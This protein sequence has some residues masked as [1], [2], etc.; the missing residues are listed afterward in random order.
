MTRWL[1]SLVCG[2]A[3]SFGAAAAPLAPGEV[4]DPLKSWVPWV[5]SDEAQ[6]GCPHLFNSAETRH[7][8]WPAV[9]ELKADA[10]GASFA[11]QWRAYR[12]TWAVLPGD[13]RQWP[14]EVLVDGKPA[15]VLS[16]DGLPAVRLE[17]GVHRISGRFFWS[18]LPLSLAL[19]AGAGLLQL[20]L[21]GKA[22]ALP[23]RDEHN[24]LL[25]Q[26][27]TEDREKEQ[28]QLRVY[29]KIIDGVPLMVETRL[30]LEV[31]GKNRE[32][33]IGRVLLPDLIPSELQS[34]LPAVLAEDGGLKLQA[35][36][37]TWDVVLLA[38]H[39]GL[40]A[41]LTLP[42][43]SG[44]QAEEE[45]WVFQAAP[46]VRSATVEGPPAVDPQQTTLPEE[47]RSLPS[48]L[49]RPKASFGLKQVRRGDSD[50]APDKLTLK[51]RLWLGFDGASMTAR[52]S[53]AGDIS[54]GTRLTLIGKGQLGRVDVAG[55]DQLIT[56]GGD[57]MAGI[58]VKRGK[59][60]M[61]ADSLLP[62]AVRRFAAVGWKHDFDRL[63]MELALPAGWRLLHA[64]GA[65]HQTGAWLSNWNLLDVF[66]VLLI[67]L[68]AG[69][70]WG[71]AWGVV[72]LVF[73]ILSYQE[74]N[75]PRFAWLLLLLAT[76]LWQALPDGRV[77][78]WIERIKKLSWFLLL[79]IALE[80]AAFEVRSALYPVL[81]RQTVD[82]L[83]FGPRL[84]ARIDGFSAKDGQ[85]RRQAEAN[86]RVQELEQA[87]TERGALELAK[88]KA[89]E[90]RAGD[91]VGAAGA[92][93]PSAKPRERLDRFA[94][95]VSSVSDGS[96]LKYAKDPNAKV[97]TGP[98]LPDWHWHAISL[99]W[100]GPVRQDQQL[101]LWLLSPVMNKFL[102]V[103][104]LLLLGLLLARAGGRALGGLGG[105][106][107]GG[108]FGRQLLLV[109]LAL[110]ALLHTASVWAQMPEPETLSELKS[111][112]T[113]PAECLPE[114]AEIS[115]LS[116]QAA[117]GELRLGLEVDAA[118][119]TALPL[120]GGARQW[121]P[122][123]ALLDGKTA[124]VQR[125][126]RGGLWLLTPAGHH[127]LELNGDLPHGDTLQLPLPR[128]PR[129]VDV[130]AADWDVSG[131]SDDTGAADTLQL[132]RRRSAG[133]QGEAPVLPPFLQVERR[134][135]LDLL[136]R[137]ETTVRRNSP[138]GVPA[139]AEVPLLPG[140]AVTSAGVNVK[141]GKVMVNLGPQVATLSW[142][143]NLTQ[144]P[145]IVLAAGR[146]L[147]WM[148][149][150]IVAASTTWH[151]G[152]DG[153]P[154][155]AAAP[156]Q[157]IDPTYRPWPGETLTL[158]IDRP[159]AVA[160][161]SL[162]IDA[163]TLTL[164]PG[165]RA[166]NYLLAMVIRSSRGVDHTVMLPDGTS[167]QR[168]KING[169]VRPI[170]AFGRQVSL[171]LVPGKQ[172]I[173]LAWR[174]DRGIGWSYDT[175]PVD[176]G[177]P[178]V[179]MRLNIKW[180]GER[181]LLLASGPGIGSVILFW[182]KLLLML[183]LGL[184][185][186]RYAS[187]K[188]P[189]KTRDWLLLALG[190]TQ[191]AN[192]AAV[193]VVCWFF[194]FAKRADNAAAQPSRRNFNMRQLA[195]PVLTL[196]MLAVLFQVVRGGLLGQPD[197][198]VAGVG[199]SGN[200]NLHWYLDRV[201][202]QMPTAWV[203]SLPILVYRGLML[204][205]ALWLAWSLLAWLQWGWGIYGKDGYWRK[206]PPVDKIGKTDSVGKADDVVNVEPAEPVQDKQ[207]G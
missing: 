112:L 34:P 177:L 173:E 80:F 77:K 141:D 151:V 6:H 99:G 128:K 40:A 155:V 9:L 179:N 90:T 193:L 191:I 188:L 154:P 97:Q 87:V 159:P 206:R 76:A 175:L 144:R 44:L 147:G 2:F 64:G 46:L 78:R 129:R 118:I 49:M 13:E 201:P 137:V 169:V 143:S 158:K 60:T 106:G 122:R 52:D 70:L 41:A 14:Q 26:R 62:G 166:S 133:R 21:N 189:M 10:R 27:K 160:G 95:S 7:C 115:R 56:R 28:A 180:P 58:E 84:F 38:R 186:G 120:P 85:A 91:E 61:S 16:Q 139:L 164:D 53:I 86:A 156:D 207:N 113:R 8:A 161:Q 182:S 104:R 74:V 204:L 198:Q 163:V 18:A 73:L 54:R 202:A 174:V 116:V 42:P 142:S 59:L 5:L 138:L 11:Q 196:L 79:L 105:L 48:Y 103:L 205:W 145:E 109:G 136:W 178:S 47:W 33:A 203:L 89:E 83:G 110:T 199:S 184:L 119:D 81:E 51:R 96:V 197:M 19:P 114:C 69:R 117:G 152:A 23:T 190:M 75:A 22:V 183:I 131:L 25:L 125:D 29:R 140:E 65:D 162:T 17:V 124:F 30:R 200:A 146:G 132:T 66:L 82:L 194:A 57:Q 111:K 45:V 153:I 88:R 135:V 94:S 92:E 123:E 63:E 12:E 32:L 187:A 192:L 176:L 107:G 157:D 93:A 37:G 102:A 24:S 134:L 101:D 121:L 15:T 165:A 181:W 35:R 126:A 195:L 185:L 31:S 36:A 130:S 72:A 39:P 1:L 71:R 3:L 167:L 168:V 172:S 170:R 43:A 20:D 127:R 171:P 108:G 50:P 100:D 4:P 67:A 150:W 98:G 148:E 55:Q 68:A 149:T